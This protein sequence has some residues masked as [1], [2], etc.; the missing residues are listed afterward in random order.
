MSEQVTTTYTLEQIAEAVRAALTPVMIY[1]YE[2]DTRRPVTQA[3]VDRL[4]AVVR[5]FGDAHKITVQAVEAFRS[6]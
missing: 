5:A 4:T 2:T 6:K 3:D 1:D